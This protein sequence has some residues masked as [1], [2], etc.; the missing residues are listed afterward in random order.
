MDTKI[1][2]EC[3]PKLGDDVVCS[4][5]IVV[6]QIGR[7]L[8]INGRISTKLASSSPLLART[9]TTIINQAKE[10]TDCDSESCIYSNILVQKKINKNTIEQELKTRFKPQGPFDNDAWLDNIHIDSVLRQLMET[11][12]HFYAI[13]FQ[14]IDF[15]E[16]GTELATINLLKKI[17]E[18][19]TKIAVVLNTDVSDGKG[20]HWFA[21]FMDFAH[22]TY[23]LEFFNSS[24]NLPVH[25]IRTWQIETKKMFER[26]GFPTKCIIVSPNEIQKSD[27]E[28]GVFSLWFIW[29]RLE[30]H[31]VEEFKNVNMGPDDKRMVE[32]RKMLFRHSNGTDD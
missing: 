17:N 20:K 32:F 26:K 5:D 1:A 8:N 2:T 15:K 27:S 6:K 24:G 9:K 29:S 21:M 22:D 7:A 23:S 13:P 3:H 4:S 31:P 28:C 10:K 18:G 19:Y 11:Y 14:M 16:K 25:Q 30:N 12:K